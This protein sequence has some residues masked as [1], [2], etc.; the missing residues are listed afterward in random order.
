M[1]KIRH[2]YQLHIQLCDIK[3]AIWRRLVVSDCTNLAQLHRLIQ[4]AMGWSPRHDY[5]FEIADQRYGQ[6]NPD[7]PEDPTMDARRYSLGQLLQGQALPM[8]Y[9]YNLSDEWLHR[10]KLEACTPLPS[11]ESLGN[12]P[13]CLD[14][15]NTCQPDSGSDGADAPPF[16]LAS[17]QARIQALARARTTPEARAE[18]ALS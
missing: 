14:G 18:T 7:W 9:V 15:R 4:A 12:L 17:T 3:P 1:P 16:D 13:L 8:R 6:P 5:L 10:I 11:P 2:S